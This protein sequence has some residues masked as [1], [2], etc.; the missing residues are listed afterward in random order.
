MIFKNFLN[1]IR[2]SNLPENQKNL[3]RKAMLDLIKP[4]GLGRFT[5]QAH[6]KKIQKQIHLDGF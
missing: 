6:S 2:E 1:Q 5:V 3:N 4:N